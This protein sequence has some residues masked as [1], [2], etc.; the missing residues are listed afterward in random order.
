M[1]EAG[2]AGVASLYSAVVTLP[3]RM[4]RSLATSN[5]VV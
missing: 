4:P 1:W 5:V 2:A 3:T